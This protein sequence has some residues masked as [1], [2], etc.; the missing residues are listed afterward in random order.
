[1]NLSA[2]RYVSDT[3]DGDGCYT[4]L[5]NTAPPQP[6]ILN[7]PSTIHGGKFNSISWGK[8]TDPDGDTVTYKLEC[9][10]N[11][12]SFTQIYSGTSTVYAHLVPFGANSV[13]Y[14]VIATDPS[15]ASS[16]YKYTNTLTVVNNYAPVISGSDANLGVKS[17]GF[18]G[19]YTVTD[20]N[21]DT[22]TVTESIDGVQI[23]SLVATL[24]STITYGVTEG[25]WL[26][27]PNGSHTLTIRATD[28]V[29][30]SVRTLV[31]TKQVNS[32]TIRNTTPW[33]SSTMPSRIMIVV[34]RNLPSAA[35]FKVEVCNNGYDS[36]P[37]WEDCT[38]AVKSG[39]VHV[40]SNKTKTA[41]KWG[42][43]VRVTVN[44]NGAIGACYVSAI[45]GNF[46]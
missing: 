11:K 4:F 30:A 32:F 46:E 22:V 20:A 2:G 16:E 1:M 29:D 5:W 15:G 19:T 35:T 10:V 28:G 42:V 14:R 24:G 13:Q 39:R 40:L 33:E 31:F 9:S 37:T 26:A 44:R 12:E 7:T 18:T 41:S 45:G 34:T 43:I 21:S 3:T 17:S 25:T 6:T 38:D 36:S 8:V 23:R 27:L